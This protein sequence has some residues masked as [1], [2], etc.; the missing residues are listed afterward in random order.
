[1]SYALVAWIAGKLQTRKLLEHVVPGCCT[2]GSST[3]IAK[4]IKK[5]LSSVTTVISNH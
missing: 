1:M 2:R 5:P 4:G 3:V